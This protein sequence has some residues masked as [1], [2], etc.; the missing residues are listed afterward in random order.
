MNYNL[1]NDV[2]IDRMA[3]HLLLN[4]KHLSG[5]G[6]LHGKM[7]GVLFFFSYSQYTGKE[8][9]EDYACELLK[10]IQDELNDDMPI[11]FAYGL[12]G[13]GWGIEYLIQN[14]LVEGNSDEILEEIDERVM[15]LDPRR[16]CDLSLDRGLEGIIL[17]V[18]ARL[19]SFERKRGSLPFDHRYLADIDKAISIHQN[20]ISQKTVI[21]YRTYL[22][23]RTKCRSPL[24]FPDEFYGTCSYNIESMHRSPLGVRNGLTGIALKMLFD[25]KS[26]HI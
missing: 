25:E 9:Y 12:C 21:Y 11:N 22:S 4:Y 7:G 14:G 23:E 2:L 15:A 3:T 13:I 6:L 17:Y 19:K 20:N 1:L 26:I 8:Y 16:L 24:S 18:T 10:L 5:S